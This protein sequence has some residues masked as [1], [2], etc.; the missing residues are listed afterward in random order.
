MKKL[1]TITLIILITSCSS[2]SSKTDK[3]KAASKRINAV[4]RDNEKLL[5]EL[6]E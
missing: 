2:V 3:I 1:L 5:K 6:D 4:E